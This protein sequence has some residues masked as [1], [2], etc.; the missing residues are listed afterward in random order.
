M[1]SQMSGCGILGIE[2]SQRCLGLDILS[3]RN[4]SIEID[5][6]KASR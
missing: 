2:E 3:G 4:M 1:A 5:H 6:R